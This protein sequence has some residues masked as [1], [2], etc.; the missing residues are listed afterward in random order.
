MFKISTIV[1]NVF[2]SDITAIVISLL[3]ANQKKLIF[4]IITY[5]YPRSLLSYLKNTGLYRIYC[6]T[7]GCYCFQEMLNSAVLDLFPSQWKKKKSFTAFSYSSPFLPQEIFPVETMR[8]AAQLGF[9]GIYVRPE[10]GGSGLSRLDTS[11][12]FEALSTGCVSTTAYISIHKYG[13]FFLEMLY[14]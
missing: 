8:R 5:F 14:G 11:I 3:Y 6:F 12:I 1:I 2:C 13:S 9:G 4:S 10:V 7:C